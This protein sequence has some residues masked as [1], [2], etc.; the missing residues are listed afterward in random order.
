MTA[1]QTVNLGGSIAALAGCLTFVLIYS[2]CAPWWRS[3]VGRL[4]VFKALA[5]A[6]FMTVSVLE[7]TVDAD[8]GAGLGDL[9]MVR[10]ILA[11][12]F[13]VMMAYQA[14]LV[15]RTQARGGSRTAGDL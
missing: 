15:G 1:G 8:D 2:L 12:G 7:Y 11:A 6:A 4:L 9:L 13:G 3:H 5:I 10:G 14:W